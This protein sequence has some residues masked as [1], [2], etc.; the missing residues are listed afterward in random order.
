M[1]Q[2]FYWFGKEGLHWDYELN[3]AV[4]VAQCWEF[5]KKNQKQTS[6]QAKKKKTSKIR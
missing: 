2:D 3:R 1:E 5:L 4:T 6:K